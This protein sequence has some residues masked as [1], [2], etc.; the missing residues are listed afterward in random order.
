MLDL[1]VVDS[2]LPWHVLGTSPSGAHTEPW[3]FVVVS[4][5]KTKREIRHIIEAEEEINYKKRMGDKWV[6][7]L[8][9]L[10]TDWNKPYL[11]LGTP[12]IQKIGMKR[13]QV[14]YV[15][16]HYQQDC[17]TCFLGWRIIK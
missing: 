16:K 15:V 11:E 9:R 5:P 2:V 4:D 10:R 3:T 17:Q 8:K 6:N 14:M 7:D 12:L 1:C 13:L